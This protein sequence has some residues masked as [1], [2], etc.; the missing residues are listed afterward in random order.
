[1]D[2]IIPRKKLKKISLY[3]LFFLVVLIILL[4]LFVTYLPV[5]VIDL[6]V[7]DKIQSKGDYTLPM[8]MYFVSFIGNLYPALITVI[9]A[10]L[11]YF[12]SG[13][14]KE[15]FFV[16]GVFVADGINFIIKLL[17]NRPRPSEEFVHILQ[18]LSDPSFPS[19]HVVHFTVFFGFILLTMFTTKKVNNFFRLLISIISI[20]LIALI[21][22][23]RIYLGAHW[24]TDV[25]GGYLVGFILLFFLVNLY[26]N[27]LIFPNKR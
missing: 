12:V 15:A 26:L 20:S 25:I 2:F 7:S 27:N 5:T 8:I 11:I 17:I 22:I 21:S 1:M 23:S 19:G 14:K 13:N 3:L 16:L 24:F 18:K 4:A 6:K 9:S 10:S